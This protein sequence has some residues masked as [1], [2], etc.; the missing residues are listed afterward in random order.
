MLVYYVETT[1]H[2]KSG[3]LLIYLHSFYA[4]QTIFPLGAL[5][6]CTWEKSKQIIYKRISLIKL[7]AN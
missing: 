3:L 5:T 2:P 7:L 4:Q 6:I 1:N